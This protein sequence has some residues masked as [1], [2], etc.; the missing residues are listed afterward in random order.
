MPLPADGADELG[1]PDA[2]AAA[3]ADFLR[4]PVRRDA[5]VRRAPAPGRLAPF[6][7]AVTL[8]LGDLAT[9]RL[10]YLYDPHG[11]PAWGGRDRLVAF[12]RSSVEAEMALDPLLPEVVWSW[13][14][15]AITARGGALAAPAGTVT[16]TSNT[17]FG[18]I[19]NSPAA[20]DLELRCSWSPAAG[21]PGLHLAAFSDLLGIMAGL[22]PDAP[23]V[24]ALPRRRG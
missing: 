11:Q 16:V 13:L 23:E 3:A 2:F 21:G 15:E 24:V 19:A 8:D 18:T 20:H 1:R 22:P 9:G 4:A 7:E 12:A 10:V 5:L 14:G 17:R 6:S